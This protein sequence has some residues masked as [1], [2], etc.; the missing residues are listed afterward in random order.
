MVCSE[1]GGGMCGYGYLPA[2]SSMSGSVLD[3]SPE[4]RLRRHQRAPKTTMATEQ[5][6]G[7]CKGAQKLGPTA[8]VIG[9]ADTA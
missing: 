7:E 4:A 2:P 1:G 3:A 6:R 5:E 8:S 9:C